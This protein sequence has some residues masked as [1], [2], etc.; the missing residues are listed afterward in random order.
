MLAGI[1][2]ELV[3]AA[4]A[5]FTWLLA[6]D[7]MIR[8]HAVNLMVVCGVSTLLFNANPLMRYDGYYVLGDLIGST[9]LRQEA[10]DAF[11]SVFI[12]QVA[13]P[14]YAASN[15]TNSRSIGLAI[16]HVMSI[17][18]RMVVLSAIAALILGI[19][20]Y[21]QVRQFA[22]L[23]LLVTG[24]I[25]AT[26]FVRRIAMVAGG[27]GPWKLVSRRRRGGIILGICLLIC[28]ALFVPLPRYRSA[29]GWIDAA[30][31]TS[32]YL[33]HA[34]MIDEVGFD[35]GD[36]VS[37]GD[38]LVRLRS[39][40]LEFQ[41]AKLQGKL[42]LASLRRDLSRRVSLDR[43]STAGQWN[44]LKVAEQVVTEQLA[45]VNQRIEKSNVQAPLAGVVL[46]PAPTV[47]PQTPA[48]LSLQRRTGTAAEAY[49]P[50]CR[51]TPTGLIQAVLI[52]DARDRMNV[53]AGSAVKI[54]VSRL[55]E[56]VF[57]STIHS[58]S[59]IQQES[60][61]VTR[62]SQYQVL[63]RLPAAGETEILHWLGCEC[64]AVFHLPHR[65]LASDIARWFQSWI[66]G[67]LS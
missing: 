39:D 67:E 5:T 43:N 26:R 2:V 16:Y 25:I 54:S 18:Y 28:C 63:C 41:R 21:F 38:S 52:L 8:L 6:T 50:W 20:E 65:S 58:V 53:D 27:N 62:R 66:D 48:S 10:R 56:D 24:L 11:Q 23:A 47:A 37:E 31:T 19:A 15:Q 42:R 14:N 17:A 60:E 44:T 32:V 33:S 46:P 36:A 9:N 35:F 64:N 1:Y 49:Q 30:D 51:I 13:G 3:L 22:V 34:G 55:R 61:S 7:P 59:A 57:S 29:V 40:A 45:S 12:K 4:L